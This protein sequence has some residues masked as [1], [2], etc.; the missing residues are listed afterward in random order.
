M[1]SRVNGQRRYDA[2]GRRTR[3]AQTRDRMLETAHRLFLEGGYGQTT[4]VSIAAEAGVS[5]ELIY[6]AFGGKAGLVRALYERSLLGSNPIPAEQRSDVIQSEAVDAHALLSRLGVFVTEIAPL[7]YPV[8]VL[9]RDA[10]ASGDSA[11]IA[12][13]KQIEAGRHERMTHNAGTLIDRGLVPRSLSVT[14]VADVMWVYTSID[15]YEKLVVTRGWS[16]ESFGAFVGTA[17][18]AALLDDPRQ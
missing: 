10:A 18:S 15:L 5:P 9:I 12:L 1:M 16:L 8:A 3:A 17:L 2:S 6:S 14:H 4:I 11:M 13:L 7:A